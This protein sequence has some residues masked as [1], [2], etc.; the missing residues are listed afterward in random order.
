MKIRMEVAPDSK[1]T[2]V[3]AGDRVVALEFE[4]L[5]SSSEGTAVLMY[6]DSKT[7]E[8][9]PIE[10]FSLMVSGASG[11]VGKRVRSQ[12]VVAKIDKPK[13]PTPKI[14][15]PPGTTQPSPL[16]AG[17]ESPPKHIRPNKQ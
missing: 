10:E 17:G 5:F 15:P 16:A 1:V 9:D 11:K 8:G 4:P 14:D 7:N 12:K 2:A 13:P 3:M 6:G